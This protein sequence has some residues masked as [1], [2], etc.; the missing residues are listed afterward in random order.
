MDITL[1]GGGGGRGVQILKM[2]MQGVE[3]EKKIMQA[4]RERNVQKII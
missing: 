2:S 4:F 3:Y 1:V